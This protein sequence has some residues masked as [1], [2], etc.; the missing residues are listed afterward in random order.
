[1]DY[2]NQASDRATKKL[3]TALEDQSQNDMYN[4]P[5]LDFSGG[6]DPNQTLLSQQVNSYYLN[7]LSVNSGFNGGQ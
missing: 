5:P 2:Q 6:Q 7:K 1:M 3:G 4:S